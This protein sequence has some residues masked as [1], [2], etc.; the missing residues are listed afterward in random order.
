MGLGLELFGLVGE[1]LEFVVQGIQVRGVGLAVRVA[2]QELRESGSFS[3]LF[4]GVEDG[5]LYPQVEI[6]DLG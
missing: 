5:L 3:L 1:G 2:E 6:L 4:E